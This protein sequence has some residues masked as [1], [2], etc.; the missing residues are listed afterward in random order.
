MILLSAVPYERLAWMGAVLIVVVLVSAAA[1]LVARR[2][3]KSPGDSGRQN[4]FSVE[5]LQEMRDSGQISPEEFA[6]LRRLALGLGPA[7]AS[8]DK[9]GDSKEKGEVE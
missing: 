5:R 2:Y 9:H 3:V 4:A 8:S 6:S 7:G 1:V